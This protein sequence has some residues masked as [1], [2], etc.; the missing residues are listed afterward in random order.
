MI[1]CMECRDDFISIYRNELKCGNSVLYILTTIQGGFAVRM[2]HPLKTYTPRMMKYREDEH[3]RYHNPPQRTCECPKCHV[4]FWSRYSED[5]P[6][7]WPVEA[8]IILSPQEMSS[9]IA[10]GTIPPDRIAYYNVINPCVI[11][12][13]DD[14]IFEEGWEKYSYQSKKVKQILP[15]IQ[16]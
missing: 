6:E 12:T 7:A 16:Y 13:K 3:G 2:K 15:T 10:D 5:Q 1:T 8:L 4:Q 11:A 9:K 14:L